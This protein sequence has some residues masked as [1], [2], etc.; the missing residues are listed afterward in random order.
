LRLAGRGES[1]VA[2]RADEY[3]WRDLGR[4]EDLQQAE[5]D[6]RHKAAL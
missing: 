2:F 5:Q 4:V 6:L 1:I 3:R